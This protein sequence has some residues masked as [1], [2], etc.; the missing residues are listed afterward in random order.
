VSSIWGLR[1][2]ALGFMSRQSLALLLVAGAMVLLPFDAHAQRVPWVVLPLVASPVVGVVLAA[3]L[4]V[5]TKSW[6]VG[7]QNAALVILW[8][9][10]FVAASNYSTSDLVVW[11]SLAALAVHSLVMLCLLVLRVLHRVRVRP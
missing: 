5:A 7:L 4:G 2:T 9:A 11:G 10:W 6:A 8:V 1:N 3:G